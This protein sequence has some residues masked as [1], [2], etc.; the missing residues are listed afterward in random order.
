MNK[1]W[2]DYLDFR[3]YDYKKMKDRFYNIRLVRQ[4]K[5]K[6]IE[7][8]QLQLSGSRLKNKKKSEYASNLVQTSYC[9][10][11]DQY[12]SCALKNGKIYYPNKNVHNR[13]CGC[14]DIN[15]IKK[16]RKSFKTI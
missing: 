6:Q 9:N 16:S 7:E 15:N 8:K 10:L 1:A 4:Q 14:N 11:K 12:R 3:K 5:H 13:Y 2:K